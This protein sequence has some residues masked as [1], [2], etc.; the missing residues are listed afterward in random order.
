MPGRSPA[1]ERNPGAANLS[2]FQEEVRKRNMEK[3]IFCDIAE[4][5]MESKIVY[6][7]DRVV[8]FKDINPQAPVHVLIIPRK[9]I[10]GVTSLEEQ[11]RELVGHMFIVSQQLARDFSVYQCGFRLVTNSGPDAGQAVNHLHIHLVAGRTL[12]WPPG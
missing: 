3:C 7:D 5:R 12:K 10:S 9:H 8:A 11:D 1:E 4:K 2:R 6:E